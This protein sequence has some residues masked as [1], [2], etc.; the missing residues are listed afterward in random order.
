LYAS[1][2]GFRAGTSAFHHRTAEI[3]RW[4]PADHGIDTSWSRMA[5]TTVGKTMRGW[6]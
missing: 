3:A 2:K 4:S 6:K 1:S 5:A